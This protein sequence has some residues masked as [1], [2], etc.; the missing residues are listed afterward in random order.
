VSGGARR[1]LVK[2]FGAGAAVEAARAMVNERKQHPLDGRAARAEDE[3]RLSQALEQM[4]LVY[5][6]I[7]DCQRKEVFAYE[8]L[9]RTRDRSFPH[10]GAVID[11][12]QRCG[13]LPDLGR[14]VRALAAAVARAVP[15]MFV[16]LHPADLL[17]PELLDLG[18]PLSKV[19]SNIVLEVTERHGLSEIADLDARLERLRVLGFRIAVDDLGEGYAG[20]TSLARIRPEFVKLDMSL[21]REAVRS[22]T[23]RHI[24]RSTS[25]MC[26]DL[27]AHVIAEGVET[28]AERDALI[29]V[30]CN[31]LQGYFFG[32]PQSELVPPTMR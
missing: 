10:P 13:R 24:V 21:V 32:R 19:A 17:D 1:Y 15:R 8:A 11:L 28:P 4:Y 9:L 22:R 29:H 26:R 25:R 23:A 12:A 6:P 7:V 30:G 16:N 3:Q 31:L 27:R 2:P 5:Q 18:S 14:R 20:L